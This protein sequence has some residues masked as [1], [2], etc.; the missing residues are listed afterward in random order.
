V[1]RNNPPNASS[2]NQV[3]ESQSNAA[4]AAS[5]LAR[6]VDQAEQS[7]IR[8]GSINA[9][10]PGIQVLTPQPEIDTPSGR[11]LLNYDGMPYSVHKRS[12]SVKKPEILGR[13]TFKPVFK[14][15]GELTP[16]GSFIDTQINARKIRINDIESLFD[17]MTKNPDSPTGKLAEKLIEE[18]DQKIKEAEADQSQIFDITNRINEFISK[19]KIKESQESLAEK[20]E[21]ARDKRLDEDDFLP[22]S[23]KKKQDFRSMLINNHS[24]T[25]DQINNFSATKLMYYLEHDIKSLLMGPAFSKV[26]IDS[27]PSIRQRIPENFDEFRSKDGQRFLYATPEINLLKPFNQGIIDATARLAAAESFVDFEPLSFRLDARDYFRNPTTHRACNLLISSISKNFLQSSAIGND[28]FINKLK[29]DFKITG[30]ARS[31]N[32]ADVLF[33]IDEN[34]PTPATVDRNNSFTKAVVYN[35]APESI[36]ILRPFDPDSPGKLN[37]MGDNNSSL[38]VNTLFHKL[39]KPILDSA[40]EG[41]DPDTTAIDRYLKEVPKK[42]RDTADTI[43]YFLGLKNPEF[44]PLNILNTALENIKYRLDDIDLSDTGLITNKTI[45]F[46]LLSAAFEDSIDNGVVNHKRKYTVDTSRVVEGGYRIRSSEEREDDQPLWV[47]PINSLLTAF[48][49]AIGKKEDRNFCNLVPDLSEPAMSGADYQNLITLLSKNA[50]YTLTDAFP[51]DSTNF[52]DPSYDFPEM[53]TLSG[54]ANPEYPGKIFSSPDNAVPITNLKR[55]IRDLQNIETARSAWGNEENLARVPGGTK[56]GFDQGSASGSPLNEIRS[57]NNIL[58][59]RTNSGQIER[60]LLAVGR[61]NE[62]NESIF[63]DILEHIEALFEASTNRGSIVDPT[64]NRM[65]S[66]KVDPSVLTSFLISVYSH[67]IHNLVGLRF[68]KIAMNS[69]GQENYNLRHF[70]KVQGVV[71]IQLHIA[72]KSVTFK[73]KNH[74]DHY[75]DGDKEINTP[76]KLKT[77]L[78]GFKEEYRGDQKVALDFVDTMRALANELEEV[79]QNLKVSFSN[80]ESNP[81]NNSAFKRVASYIDDATEPAQV[82]LSK[83]KLLSIKSKKGKERYFDDFMVNPAQ[84]NFFLT[85]LRNQNEPEA[86]NMDI[87]PVGIPFGFTRAVLG[88]NPILDPAGFSNRFVDIIVYKRDLILGKRV[89]VSKK[90]FTFDLNMFVDEVT[91][92]VVSD[93]ETRTNSIIDPESKQILISKSITERNFP[94][95]L[96]NVLKNNIKFRQVFFED[97]DPEIIPFSLEGNIGSSPAPQVFKNHVLDYVAKTYIKLTTGMEIDEQ[98]IF[99]DPKFERRNANEQDLANFHEL[100]NAQLASILGRDV[101]FADYLQ[102]DRNTREIL[103]RLTKGVKTSPII[104]EVKLFLEGTSDNQNIITSKDLMTF[105]KMLSPKNSL[106]TPGLTRD[107]VSAPKLFERVFCIFV[108]PDDFDIVSNIEESDLINSKLGSRYIDGR[109]GNLSFKQIPKSAG[110]PQATTYNVVIKESGEE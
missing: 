13:F 69:N 107:K 60:R 66:S 16:E 82:I 15:T 32:F 46:C 10:A 99:I 34:N 93:P 55:V 52:A 47:Y 26:K 106:I 35:Q 64:T 80:N 77:F 49:T 96:Q 85:M 84:E 54:I 92:P 98:N 30:E 8:M 73:F 53:R 56:V 75:I 5:R 74:L 70:W 1:P 78:D 23:L 79:V 97:K 67:I 40:S 59:K 89:Q 24:F 33:S 18:L 61:T 50:R 100:M 102:D 48:I 101:S 21:E 90:K 44:D 51:E 63:G 105:T 27:L 103:N 17:E 12:V 45:D 20:M 94:A 81:K 39:I 58:F 109:P 43:E 83:N 31:S 25:P 104:E 86:D 57:A 9:M 110:L 95:N 29:E 4:G 19:L 71:P 65:I 6:E 28:E 88:K 7:L 36:E 42:I 68:D 22:E 38:A 72:D 108:D 14:S 2:F 62:I 37:M 41:N 11:S 91:D 3:A 87:L 76:G